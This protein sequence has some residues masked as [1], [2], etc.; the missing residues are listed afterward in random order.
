MNP[1]GHVQVPETE[2]TPLPEHG[3]EQAAD[4]ISTSPRELEDMMDGSWEI[5]GTE[6][7]NTTRLEAPDRTETHTLDERARE[8]AEIGVE[9]FED[10]VDGSEAYWIW[11]P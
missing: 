4:W 11:P 7:Q 3:G 10:G 6:S 5:S 1:A 2:H 8:P 9:V